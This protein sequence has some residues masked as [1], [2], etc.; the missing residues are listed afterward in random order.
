MSDFHEE[1]NNLFNNLESPDDRELIRLLRAGDSSAFERLFLAYYSALVQFAL[2]YTDDRASAQDV[3]QDVFARIWERREDINISISVQSYLY[4]AVRNHAVTHL[5][6]N[7]ARES[8]P[9][10][11]VDYDPVSGSTNISR[12]ADIHYDLVELAQVVE[13]AV[14]G[15]PDRCQE[16]FRLYVDSRLGQLEIAEVLQIA[17][18]TVRVQIGRGMTIVRA[19]VTEYLNSESRGQDSEK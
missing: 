16:I 9:V 8:W 4:S 19:A 2:R 13:A 14:S 11:P 3:V 15:L 10:I 6:R 5:R 18:S 17:H 12:S 7:K 1:G